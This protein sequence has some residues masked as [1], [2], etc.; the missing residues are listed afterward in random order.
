M[1]LGQAVQVVAT[2]LPKRLTKAQM[3][4]ITRV[5]DGAADGIDAQEREQVIQAV[6]GSLSAVPLVPESMRNVL[7]G[8]IFDIIVGDTSLGAYTVGAAGSL[9][10]GTASNLLNQE[11]R[12]KLATR[13]NNAVDLPGLSEEQEQAIFLKAVDFVGGYLEALIPPTWRKCLQGASP[14]EIDMFKQNIVTTLDGK[15]GLPFLSAEKRQ[16]ICRCVVDYMFDSF[17]DASGLDGVVL[18]P[19]M[20]LARL[21]K[22]QSDT[23]IELEVLRRQSARR[24]AALVR[25]LELLDKQKAD[26]KKEL[27][28]HSTTYYVIAALGTVA[29][30]AA[31]VAGW[32]AL[33][34][35][36]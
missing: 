12:T 21:E 8:D 6:S 19:E 13:I 4:H 36:K 15:F 14:Q 29:V 34:P 16:G 28:Y 32:S 17:L 30:S 25:R 3:E 24:D 5:M 26:L 20:Q 2:E 22:V 11:G 1:V 35:P 7:V 31:A 33:Q 18:N 23:K 10:T 27:G 9:I